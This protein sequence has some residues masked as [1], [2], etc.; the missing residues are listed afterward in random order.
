MTAVSL[1][2]LWSVIGKQLRKPSGRTGR[3]VGWAMSLANR[4]PIRMAVAKLEVHPDS[5]V[6]DMGCGPGDALALI[7]RRLASGQAHGLDQSGTILEQAAQRNR[8]LMRRGLVKLARGEFERLP[9]QDQYF[10]RV[11]AANVAYF[12]YDIPLVLREIRRV[13]RPGGRLVLYATDAED[14]RRWKF[15]TPG[16]HRLIDA[17]LLRREAVEAGFSVEQVKVEHVPMGFGVKGI[18]AEFTR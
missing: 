15:A 17:D 9:Y 5:F 10:D 1:M 4:R 16:T 6:L 13:L 11:L 2:Q 14:M 18:L 8:S 12:W 7:G 3:L